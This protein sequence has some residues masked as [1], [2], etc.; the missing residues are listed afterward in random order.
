MKMILK[1]AGFL[2]L[3]VLFAAGTLCVG[4]DLDG[5]ENTGIAV[6]NIYISGYNEDGDKTITLEL[7]HKSTEEESTQEVPLLDDDTSS[8]YF[9]DLDSGKY[10]VA[11]ALLNDDKLVGDH[12][13]EIEIYP[14]E[15]TR[16]R[17]DGVWE[18]GEMTFEVS[19]VTSGDDGNTS[20][21]IYEFGTAY[22]E[23]RRH[24]DDPSETDDFSLMIGE[25]A[26]STAYGCTIRYP[27]GY[28][29]HLTDNLR[30]IGV[31][32]DL[33]NQYFSVSRYSYFGTGVYQAT[34]FDTNNLGD[35]ATA[36][37]D[38]GFNLDDVSCPEITDPIQG[39][40]YSGSISWNLSNTTELEKIFIYVIDTA[41][42]Y[43]SNPNHTTLEVDPT[44]TTVSP[45]IAGGSLDFELIIFA[46]DKNVSMPN[47]DY[48]YRSD[49]YSDLLTENDDSP[50][51]ISI[52]RLQF[53]GP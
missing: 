25:G 19:T 21:E 39:G 41:D 7:K 23:E 53:T 1:N 27:D 50:N 22:I 6:F 51:Y 14:D 47:P 10:D 34:I 17:I 9:S 36:N 46:V 2:L 49:I 11:V 38:D 31:N 4:C 15:T 28:E 33:G 16:S 42:R 52:A 12:D 44:T 3:I 13:F 30:N 37:I 20:V 8:G 48:Y 43:S 18:N 35:S 29:I 45:G 32:V 26:F 40:N 24:W 5:D